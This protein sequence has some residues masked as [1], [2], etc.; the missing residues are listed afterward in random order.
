MPCVEEQTRLPIKNILLATDLSESSEATLPRRSRSRPAV[1]FEHI[2]SRRDLSR[3]DLR[4][5]QESAR[6][7]GSNWRAWSEVA[8]Q[9]GLDS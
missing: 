7:L 2:F 3:S 1:R 8:V 6:R 9:P 4:D 5:R